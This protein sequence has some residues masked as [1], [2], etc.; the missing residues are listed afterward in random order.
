MIYLLEK[1]Q[2]KNQGT[3]NELKKV[4]NMFGKTVT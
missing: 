4:I 3:F 2:I 1:G